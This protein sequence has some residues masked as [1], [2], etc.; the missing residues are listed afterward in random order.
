M[1]TL[2]VLR[3]SAL[4]FSRASRVFSM[5]SFFD[6]P[7]FPKEELPPNMVLALRGLE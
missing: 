7:F 2:F 1:P 6:A 3:F 5:I 4:R